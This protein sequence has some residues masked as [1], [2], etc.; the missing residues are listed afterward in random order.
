VH[1]DVQSSACLPQA[2]LVL[3]SSPSFRLILYWI[4]PGV[5]PRSNRG[6]TVSGP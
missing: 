5:T 4:R 1:A 2:H 3:E 6:Y